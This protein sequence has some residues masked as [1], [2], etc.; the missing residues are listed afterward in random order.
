MESKSNRAISDTKEVLAVAII[1]VVIVCS[2]VFIIIPLTFPYGTSAGPKLVF[3]STILLFSGSYST[4]A[5]RGTA[6]LQVVFENPGNQVELDSIRISGLGATQNG[7]IFTCVTAFSCV[8]YTPIT[9]PANDHDIDFNNTGSAFYFSFS[10]SRSMQ[11]NC[12]FTFG[13]G[14]Q[15]QQY[16]V[17]EI[18]L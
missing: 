3:P 14:L 2:L 9:L 18:A 4:V 7:T 8:S 15:Q 5:S 10:L 6:R 12:V 1:F 11:Y 17:S 13:N 16:N